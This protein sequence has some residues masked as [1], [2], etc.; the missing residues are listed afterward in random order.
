M[1]NIHGIS[2]D[3][4]VCETKIQGYYTCIETF[5]THKDLIYSVYVLKSDSHLKF[6]GFFSF[7]LQCTQEPFFELSSPSSTLQ[8]ILLSQEKEVKHKSCMVYS[9]VTRINFKILHTSAFYHSSKFKSM[10]C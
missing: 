10:C 4:Y 2:A 9:V 5:K 6:F 8:V 3:I 1:W 7:L